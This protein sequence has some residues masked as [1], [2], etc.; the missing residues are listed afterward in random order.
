MRCCEE[1]K[2]SWRVLTV[3][4]HVT[5]ADLFCNRM[6]APGEMKRALF[7]HPF[8]SL[9]QEHGLAHG[10]CSINTWSMND[11]MNEKT[12]QNNVVIGGPENFSVCI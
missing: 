12:G 6:S 11:Y 3:T 4:L 2:R 9:C 7:W 10:T 1:G 5:R 8:N